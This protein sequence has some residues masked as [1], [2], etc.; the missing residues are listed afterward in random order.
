M[1][2]Y[3]FL[4]SLSLS[5]CTTIRRQC[6][7]YP[8]GRHNPSELRDDIVTSYPSAI[9][10]RDMLRPR[11]GRSAWRKRVLPACLGLVLF[12]QRTDET[13]LG[14]SDDRCTC[15]IN[16]ETNEHLDPRQ[17]LDTGSNINR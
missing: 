16:K 13:N 8:E 1:C 15:T 5:I 2:K 11:D 4:E 17:R 10:R 6:N 12:P 3:R 14:Q 7:M 9:V